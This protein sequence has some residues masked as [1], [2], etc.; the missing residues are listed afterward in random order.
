[1][2]ISRFIKDPLLHFLLAGGVLFIIL[3]T[4]KP[5]EDDVGIIID[6][7]ALLTFIQY[8]SK[9][10]EPSA[11][12]ALL[13]AMTP[14]QRL[15]LIN[16]YMR[17]E[18]L[19]REASAMGLDEG[20]YVIR[21]RMIQ[22]LEF[23]ADAA[24]PKSRPADEELMSFYR[25][26]RDKYAVPPGATF[27]HV[28]IS[29]RNLPRQEVEKKAQEMLDQLNS[30]GATFQDAVR[31]GDRFPFHT[32]YVERT[33]AY[34]HGHLGAEATDLIF[35]DAAPFGEW[36]GPV[37]SDYGAH[38]IYITA[39]TPL[40]TLPFA[41][42]RER[43]TQDWAREKAAENKKTVFDAVVQEYRPVIDLD[44]HL[45]DRELGEGQ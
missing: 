7:E 12:A 14:E 25:D 10:F 40:K 9:A 3:S 31:Y 22:K 33:R 45:P 44:T 19:Y 39:R 4:L 8:R 35:S 27:S 6:R 23:I 37:F 1:M 15:K 30:N 43:A 34:I 21:Q 29:F 16:D 41:D 36:I 26:N 17:E 13:D 32:N 20:D 11:A 24:L 5:P 2:Q 38:L 42:V 28:F 18:A